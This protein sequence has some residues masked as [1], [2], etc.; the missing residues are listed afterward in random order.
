M[1]QYKGLFRLKIGSQFSSS[2]Q[3]RNYGGKCESMHGHNFHVEAEVE[4]E[5][6]DPQTHI[7]VDFKELKAV[8]NEIVDGLDHRH[9]NELEP[10]AVDNPSSENLARY[11][12][13]ELQKGLSDRPVWVHQVTV[14]EKEGSQASYREV[15]SA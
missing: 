4:G 5:H 10:F 7:L 6:L 9:L 14:A 15:P 8:L 1:T 2:H 12:Y 3:L 11:I 13:A